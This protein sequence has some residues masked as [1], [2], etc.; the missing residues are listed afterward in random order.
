MLGFFQTI[1]WVHQLCLHKTTTRYC[2]QIKGST[3]TYSYM[4]NGRHIEKTFIF[5]GVCYR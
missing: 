2:L 3:L 1:M 4:S 5:T